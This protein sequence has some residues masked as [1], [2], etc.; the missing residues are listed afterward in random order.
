MRVNDGDLIGRRREVAD[1]LR[2][3]EAA[4]AG[5]GALILVEGDA[6][7]GK[8]ALARWLV[9]YAGNAGFRVAWGACLE[10]EGAA[11]YR[12][13]TQILREIGRSASLLID[14][15]G[16]TAWSRFQLFDDV[17]QK[18]R[19]AAEEHGLLV[20]LDDLHWAD[21]PS[22]RLLQAVA[23]VVAD[24]R[25]LVVGLCRSRETFPYADHVGVLR[26]IL[27]ERAAARLTLGG[28]S[29]DEITE[30]VAHTLGHPADED[31]LRAVQMR[32]EGNPL[33][34][35][36]LMRL[37]DRLDRMEAGLPR[38]IREVI[39]RR[40]D[41]LP[42]DTRQLLR[43]ASVV[44]REFTVALLGP[45]AEENTAWLLDQ[46]DAAIVAELVIVV[47]RYTFRFAHVLTQEVLYAE[48]PTTER[49][50]LHARAADGVRVAGGAAGALDALAHHLR[51]AAPLCGAGDA[52]L[53]TREA[54]ARARSQLAYEHAA[55]QYRGALDL[56]ALVAGGADERTQLLLDLARCEFRSG[57]VEDAWRSCREAADIGRVEKDACV[58]ADAATVLRGILN[59]PVTA[60]IHAMCRE[61]LAMLS[62]VDPIREA[63]VLAQLAVTADPFSASDTHG[64]GQRA[65]EAAEA[66]GD[67]DAHFFAMQA[68]QTE[69]VA[70]AYVLDR[71]SIGER[72]IR[73]GR[74]TGDDEYAAWGHT[75]RM[76]VFWELGRRVQLD[77]E[78]ATLGGLVTH[79]NEPLWLWRLTVI[80][81]AL[82]AF[83]GR[84]DDAR[85]LAE[86]ALTIGRRGGHSSAD[87][88]HLVLTT[89]LALQDGIGLEAVERGVRRFVE[90]G[91]YLARVWLADVLSG[92]GRRD[93]AEAMWSSVIPH[94]ESFPVNSKEWIVVKV[95]TARMC[96]QFEN[97]AVGAWIYDALL[98]YA[99][100]Q[101]IALA[102]IPSNG[103]VALWLG[104][105]AHTLERWD[106]AEKHLSF[107]LAAS[108]AMGS[109]PYEAL[110]HLEMARLDN[111]RRPT[112]P[113]VERHL[114]SA[115][116][117]ARGL[118]MTPLLAQATELRQTRQR[119]HA[120]ILSAREWQVAELVA[121]GLSNRQIA[122]R[123]HLSERTAENHVAHIL[124][125]LGF[126]T[127]SRI[128]SW[129]ASQ[130]TEK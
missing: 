96:S 18:L 40:L 122:N 75:W 25:L 43:Q 34:V 78:L 95:W 110:T 90:N 48:L 38:S 89:H 17:A 22:L 4:R 56:L 31:L 15:A 128:A 102:H 93:E 53:V 64:L 100:R 126:E 7:A 27:R 123:L 20:V 73:L 9:R 59:S 113:A 124:A 65:L 120:T 119:R 5:D 108:K 104:M 85:A 97:H 8:T 116:S 101:A 45:V 14:P 60:Q 91:P 50:R 30:L 36:E 2:L 41:R 47:N 1:L 109:P 69:K 42:S 28:L 10:G 66:T 92:A 37:A 115:L 77:A 49:Q 39:G 79:L 51:Q 99:D 70:P 55:F 63:R 3:L 26:A 98:P 11:P 71:L 68:L 127:R 21:V 105:L 16:G 76:N 129:Y 80:Q 29:G 81:A 87:F 58:V 61:A 130:R 86:D 13:W 24:S 82:A 62:G 54:A 83:E 72:A 114:E 111:T 94:L 44:G 33:F 19:A 46:L 121:E 112:D 67:V 106:A 74:E 117:I 12:P 103:P 107:A 32:S 118:G 84:F 23:S 88:F 6:G 52:L 125:K 57:A 35:L